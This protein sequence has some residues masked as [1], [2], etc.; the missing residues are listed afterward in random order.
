MT[1]ST[2]ERIARAEVLSISLELLL[3]EKS[4]VVRDE[5]DRL[6]LLYWSL[7]F[8]HHQG[9]LLLLRRK[10]FGTAFALM[11]PIIEAFLRLYAVMHGTDSQVAAIRNGT[12]SADFADIGAK[13][14]QMAGIE[15]LLGPFFKKN[16]KVLH[17]FTHGGLEQLHRRLRGG[18]I[19]ANY[20]DEEVRD[21][22]RFTTMFAYLTSTYVAD[23]LGRDAELKSAVEL[24]REYRD[25][26]PD[27]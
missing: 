24:Y 27:T 7:V 9:I 26:N 2:E 13:I 6:C 21:V 12:Y 23:F 11:R 15:P 8:E 20:A 4:F 16:A 14:D 22:I 18:D 25:A 3:A 19:V 17:G 10:F 5:R 1:I